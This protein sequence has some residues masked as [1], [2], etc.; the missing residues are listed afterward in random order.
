MLKV[1]SKRI[2]AI[3]LAAGIIY[4]TASDALAKNVVP[5]ITNILEIDPQDKMIE[6]VEDYFGEET[7]EEKNNRNLQ[8]LLVA[9]INNEHLS[10]QE[11]EV[12]YSLKD[13]MSENE[14]LNTLIA[15]AALSTVKVEY[16][17]PLRSG[18][19]ENVLAAYFDIPHK[20]E[21]YGPK[22]YTRDEV[23]TH[24]FIHCI[25]TRTPLTSTPSYFIEG[26]TELLNNEYISNDHYAELNSYPFEIASVK[27]LC[28]LIGSDNVLK[29][30]SK[31]NISIIKDNLERIGGTERTENFLTNLNSIFESYEA[32]KDINEEEFKQVITY[33]DSY[34]IYLKDNENGLDQYNNYLYYRGIIQCMTREEPISDYLIYLAENGILN[35]PYFSEKLKEEETSIP[36]VYSK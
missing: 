17:C 27:I 10:K 34:F 33:L 19:E 24:E 20:I 7:E 15:K 6:K 25:Y 14:Y 32:N 22:N 18:L 13:L 23:L 12:I 35:K 1:R 16:D 26:M 2:I 30:Y 31:G 29:A 36:K 9:I 11:K 4:N 21:V 8:K 28:E 3:F 5:T